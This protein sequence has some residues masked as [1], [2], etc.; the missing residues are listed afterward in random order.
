MKSKVNNHYQQLQTIG[1]KIKTLTG[2]SHLLDWDQETY[3]P[4]GAVENR[5]MQMK[6]LAGVI[7]EAKTGRKFAHA[8]SNLIDIEKK[9]ILAKGLS[10]KQKAALREWRHDYVKAKALPKGFV[11]EFAKTSSQ[12]ISAW[13]DAKNKNSFAHFSPYLDKIVAMARK[14]ADL[15]KFKE[16][17]YD[18][19]LDEY[20]PGALTSKIGQ[21]FLNLKTFSQK[22]LKKIQKAKEIDD[23][24]LFGKFSEDKQLSFS[25]LL[26][27][28]LGY[29][30]RHGRLDLSTHPFSSSSHP[31]DS[32]ITTRVNPSSLM[33]CLFAVLHEAGHALYEMGLPVE[34]Y[35]S[36]LGDSI[37]LGMHESQSRFWETRIGQSKG[38][39][40]HNLP[41]LKQHFPAQ[42]DGIS[43][44]KFY[45]AINK[46]EPNLIR[47]A[48]DEVTYSLHIILRFELEKALIEGSL[49]VRDIP[50]A[51]NARVQELLGITP[52]DDATGCLQDIHW[53]MGGFGYFPTYTLGNLYAA[54]FFETFSQDHPD[55]EEQIASGNFLFIKEWLKENIHKFGRH[56]S[57][58]E[59]LK[60]IT[61]KQFTEGPFIAYL[62]GKYGELYGLKQGH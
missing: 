10:D 24:F 47:I 3:M 51:W 40:K 5:S 60:N 15:L 44:E 37:S 49:N 16:H 35:G 34:H 42:F 46:V 61:G 55:W 38:Y 7:H 25:H 56:Y 62:S 18:A 22:L 59:L 41:L 52:K 14:K 36:P 45:Q 20:E 19:L 26:L 2:I 8:L 23:R 9:T 4:A 21:L 31:T 13:R 12:A 11:E 32:R 29:D 43:L 27:Q 58:Q 57:A 33:D 1:T 54:S 17:P 6:T 50:E 30:L 28:Q 53:S 48:S 39:W